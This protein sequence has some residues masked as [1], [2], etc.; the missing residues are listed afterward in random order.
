MLAH[1]SI[2]VSTCIQCIL[3]T[4]ARRPRGHDLVPSVAKRSKNTNKWLLY[5][6]PLKALMQYG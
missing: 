1:L 4:L 5:K 3:D 2:R 6:Y